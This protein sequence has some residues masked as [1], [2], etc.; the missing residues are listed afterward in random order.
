MAIEAIKLDGTCTGEHGI[1]TGKKEYLKMEM[2]DGTM[3]VM[4]TIK[5]AMDPHNILNPGKIL[6]VGDKSSSR[7]S[8]TNNDSV[9]GGHNSHV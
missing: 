9:D 6:D 8:G 4:E 1:G 2:G 7:G 3:R 5:V